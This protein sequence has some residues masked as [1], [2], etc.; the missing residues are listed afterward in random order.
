MW[1]ATSCCGGPAHSCHAERSEASGHCRRS[2]RRI[3]PTDRSKARSFAVAQ[4]DKTGAH[5]ALQLCSW[6]WALV[7]LVS[8]FSDAPVIGGDRGKPATLDNDP[9]L[10]GW[11][12]FDETA[13]ST[14][15]DSSGH[16]RD[17][18][19]VGGF[20]FD[21]GT[22]AGK[23]GQAIRFDTKDAVIEIRDYKG[24]GGTHAR[25]VAAWIKTTSSQGEIVSWGK[26]DFGQMFTLGY[27][28]GRV[29][30]TPHGGYLYMNAETHDDKW[31]HVAVAVQKAEL[32]N[33]YDDVKLY[34][35]GAPAEIHDIGLLD[36][37]PVQT[38][39]EL[40]VRIG[41]G[42]KGL[43]DDLRIYDRALSEEE[44]TALFKL[45]TGQP[46]KKAK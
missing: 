12:K 19:L 18:T 4:D 9:N 21:K 41:R 1:F 35:D 33:L 7:L 2:R 36:L 15:A 22:A 44:I 23:V 26:R 20:T 25:T 32:P 17:G 37:W 43:V 14:A 29:G 16:K 45:Q 40:P 46:L 27:I 34:L 42:F 11:W 8:A 31:H 24:I 30:V 6:V 39:Q 10:V 5:S 3:A 38:G 28:R 13:G